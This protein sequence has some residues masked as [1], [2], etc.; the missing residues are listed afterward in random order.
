MTQSP[1][2]IFTEIIEVLD[3]NIKLRAVSSNLQYYERH[4]CLRYKTESYLFIKC[5]D[6][7]IV[8]VTPIK[9]V[10]PILNVIYRYATNFVPVSHQ[11]Q[12]EVSLLSEKDQQEFWESVL[13]FCVHHFKFE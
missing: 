4:D 7:D 12:D 1:E 6:N 5:I 2:V 10:Q 8:T 11:L 13:H 3:G 9:D